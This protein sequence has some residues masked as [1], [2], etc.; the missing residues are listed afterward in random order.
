MSILATQCVDENAVSQ[1]Q[2]KSA[3]KAGRIQQLREVTLSSCSSLDY[4]WI[5]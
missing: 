5:Q 3:R 4:N 2:R 1:D